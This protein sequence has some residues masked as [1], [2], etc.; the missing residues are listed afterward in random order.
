LSFRVLAVA[1][2]AAVWSALAIAPAC[3][4][5]EDGN[6]V[7]YDGAYFAPFNVATAEDMLKRIPG[8]QDIVTAAQTQAQQQ[9]AT[10]QTARRGF[11]AS[12]DQ[13][14]ID[15][16]RLSGKTN[17]IASALQRIQAG[18]VLRIEVIRGNVAGLDVRS[19]GTIV[20]VVL[21]DALA[22]GSGTWE[23]TASHFNRGQIRY[24]GRLSYA[25]DVGA[26]SYIAGLTAVPRFDLRRRIDPLKTAAG[27]LIEE[28]EEY[29]RI[30]AT[31]VTA[32]A[33]LTY[34][35]ANGDRANLN[36]RFADQG[37][38][39]HEP[40]DRYPIVGGAR[41]FLVTA[42]MERDFKSRN[43][44]IGGDVDHTFQGGSVL[45]GLFVAN[46]SNQDDLREF[47]SVSATGAKRLDRIQIQRPDRSERI[48]RATYRLDLTPGQTVEFGAEGATNALRQTIQLLSNATGTLRDVPLFNPDTRINE[49]RFETYAAHTWQPADDLLV[50]SAI[51]TEYSRIRQR[52]RDVNQASSFFFVKPRLDVRYDMAPLWQVRARAQRTASQLDF[53]GF[54]VGFL[55]DDVANDVIRSGNP[56]LVPEKAWEFDLGL[57]RRLADD[58][59]VLTVEGFYNRIADKVE[60]VEVRGTVATGNIGTG[61]EYGARMNVGL[62]LGF[63]GLP[64]AS[65]DANGTLRHTSVP[66]GFT[67]I[68]R[69][70]QSLPARQVIISVRNDMAWRSLAYGATATY[71]SQSFLWDYDFYQV[72][73]LKTQ[74]SAFVEM[75][76]VDGLTVRVD[77]KRF[78]GTGAT[79][80]RFNYAGSRRFDR[81][82]TTEIRTGN[83]GR[84]YRLSLRGR[85]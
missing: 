25:G 83:F 41:A 43:W 35:F 24:G 7:V 32:T 75:Q 33:G 64:R 37:Q 57:E 59:G 19:E 31:D 80:D 4:Q 52:G 28:Q 76:L 66:D 74:F 38:D 27:V 3:A 60:K 44:E 13:I 42:L 15:G 20:N 72:V 8:I 56:D 78:I 16:R 17:N 62:R 53:A 79:R 73:R 68:R 12:G 14:L 10:S 30:D 85:F 39:E 48:L 11:G 50:E 70:F 36:G 26:L 55:N 22:T 51:D 84:E 18:Q 63:V 2:A 82:L 5:S 67:R 45:K 23:G 40:S 81:L 77:G 58:Q 21:K 34:N 47:S 69:A 49:R 61:I 71:Q 29:Q 1:T 65:I 54:L 9:T 6:R 46:G